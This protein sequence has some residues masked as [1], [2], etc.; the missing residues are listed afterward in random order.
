MTF[1][2]ETLTVQRFAPTVQNITL[3]VQRFAPTV[4]NITLTVQRVALTVQNVAATVQ[5]GAL[6]VQR[7]A[8]TVQ[9]STPTAQAK[10]HKIIHIKKPAGFAERV[11]LIEN[12]KIHK[13]LSIVQD[14]S[15]IR[16]GS[17]IYNRRAVSCF[18]RG[19]RPLS[20][21]LRMARS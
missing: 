1:Q 5:K 18:R 19:F 2:S 14:R 20:L 17:L 10:P 9:T 12:N 8:L 6:T 13:S 16:S 21:L 7:I 4:Q 3:T 11:F 15:A